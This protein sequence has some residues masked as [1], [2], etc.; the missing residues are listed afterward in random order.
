MKI[1][2]V[3]PYHI[4]KGGGVQECVF[5]LQK[6]LEARGHVARIITPLPRDVDDTDGVHDCIDFV[7]TSANVKSPFHTTAQVS[8]SLD[9]SAM[10][11]ML[12]REQF[13][14]LH[15]HEPWVPIMSRQ[16]LTQSDTVNVATFHAKLPETVMS[17]TIERVVTP[18]TKSVLKYLD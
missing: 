1:G 13:D 4:F 10:A 15:F 18:Y 7:G 3:C 16:L 17:K 14:V 11:E 9:T 12:E 8:V 6:E 2:L 5:A